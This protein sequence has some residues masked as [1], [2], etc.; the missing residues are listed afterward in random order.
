MRFSEFLRNIRT[1]E[2]L[3][4]FLL[5]LGIPTIFLF[6]FI[7]FMENYDIVK[8]PSYES[9]LT[10]GIGDDEY[11]RMRINNDFR[12]S[13]NYSDPDAPH[14]VFEYEKLVKSTLLNKIADMSLEEVQTLPDNETFKVR[15]RGSGTYIICTPLQYFTVVGQEPNLKFLVTETDN[16][17]TLT[18]SSKDLIVNTLAEQD[19]TTVLPGGIVLP[20]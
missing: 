4:A 20:F 6:S 3:K 18:P 14:L 2:F 7:Y 15:Q 9:R 12:Q 10:D 5:V 11:T 16:G 8:K 13:T 19:S 17:L 1:K